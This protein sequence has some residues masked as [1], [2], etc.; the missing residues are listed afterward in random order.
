MLSFLNPRIVL[1][2]AP[3]KRG[4]GLSCIF[5]PFCLSGCPPVVPPK[6]QTPCD[7]KGATAEF[8][9]CFLNPF[10][11]LME[12]YPAS[13]TDPDLSLCTPRA[14]PS[15]FSLSH[16][17]LLVDEFKDAFSKSPPLGPLLTTFKT[18]TTIRRSPLSEIFHKHRVR[19]PPPTKSFCQYRLF[20]L[21][22]ASTFF[23]AYTNK[24]A[25][26]PDNSSQ[27]ISFSSPF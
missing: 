25:S 17:L 15:I 16:S 12:P 22:W 8:L 6:E 18:R 3:S 24:E 11:L 21:R 9:S 7:L 13:A 5:V 1:S 27:S 23:L 4:C 2:P 10:S 14:T 20:F 19:G 26:S